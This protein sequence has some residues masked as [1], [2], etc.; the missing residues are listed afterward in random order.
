MVSKWG[1]L[2]CNRR[3]GQVVVCESPAPPPGS[4]QAF[5]QLKPLIHKE[6]TRLST[7]NGALYY[8]VLSLRI[9][10]SKEKTS[11]GDEGKEGAEGEDTAEQ[12]GCG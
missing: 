12:Q 1:V 8:Y 4:P 9:N 2:H 6:K 3:T 10:N 7:K 5:H 11:S